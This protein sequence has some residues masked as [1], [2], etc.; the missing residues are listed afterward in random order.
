MLC[1]TSAAP[2]LG[3]P[4]T[5][6]RARRNGKRVCWFYLLSLANSVAVCAA[7]S[8]LPASGSA[9]STRSTTPQLCSARAAS[10][11]RAPAPAPQPVRSRSRAARRA[12][13]RVRSRSLCRAWAAKCRSLRYRSADFCSPTGGR[14]SS[15][16]AGWPRRSARRAAP[17][18]PCHRWCSRLAAHG[19]TKALSRPARPSAAPHRVE[20]RIEQH[21]PQDAHT[22]ATGVPPGQGNRRRLMPL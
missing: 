21:A 22:S 18:H 4:V 13:S 14:K 11:T 17:R 1:V 9:R 10:Q 19:I 6:D 12:Q 15:S 3:H 16:H 7:S 5:H 20:L 8:G 2:R